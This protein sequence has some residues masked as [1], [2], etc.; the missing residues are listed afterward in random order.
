MIKFKHDTLVKEYKCVNFSKTMFRF[1]TFEAILLKQEIDE[2]VL[3]DVIGR[4]VEIYSP[5]E[6]VIAEK[7]SR[8]IDFVL[9]DNSKR[10]VKFT[11]W[12][13]HVDQLSPY[14]NSVGKDPVILLIQMCSVKFMDNG[15]VRICSSFDATQLFTIS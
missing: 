4:L 7:M 2:K 12:D 14:F 15:E 1:K 6:K 11:L 9:E 5:Q 13:D 10:Q 3:I 8:L